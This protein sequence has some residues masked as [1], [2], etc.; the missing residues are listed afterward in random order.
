M[1]TV[2]E[3]LERRE[4][5]AKAL[6]RGIVDA[7]PEAPLREAAAELRSATPYLWL[8]K[9]TLVAAGARL[10]RHVISRDVLPEPRM[11]WMFETALPVLPDATISGLFLEDT[12]EGV[13][14]SGITLQPEGRLLVRGPALITY[15]AT[16][17]DDFREDEIGTKFVAESVLAMLAFLR[18]RHIVVTSR[19]R[20]R[21]D[22]RRLAKAGRDDEADAE[23]KFVELRRPELLDRQRDDREKAEPMPWS[24]RWVIGHPHAQW[25]P[26]LGAHRL[27]FI[28]PYIKGPDDK[29][30]WPRAFR[31]S[32]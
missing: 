30:L 31:V 13:E 19:R 2:A 12:V 25:Y 21:A 10:P 9:L 22:R 7:P 8:H 29:P 1:R 18:S 15:G 32:R 6:E 4:L 5:W 17:P 16:F 26:S 20:E 14:V 11:V 3:V 28:A 27:T 24:H 23:A